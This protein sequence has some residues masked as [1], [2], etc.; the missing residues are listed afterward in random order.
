M[1]AAI[2]SPMKFFRKNSLRF[3]LFVGILVFLIPMNLILLG[4]TVYSKQTIWQ[5]A[6]TNYSDYVTLVSKQIDNKL[7]DI[8]T[9]VANIFYVNDFL[10]RMVR[11]DDKNTRYLDAQE[12]NSVVTDYL[13]LYSNAMLFFIKCDGISIPSVSNYSQNK[14]SIAMSDYIHSLSAES[15]AYPRN[16]YFLLPLDGEWYLSFYFERSGIYL[17]MLIE[18]SSLLNTLD[19]SDA[20]YV[21]TYFSDFEGTP[22]AGEISRKDPYSAADDQRS[23]TNLTVES[24]PATSEYM[25]IH[26]PL[27]NAPAALS[28]QVP[29][30]RI[31]G[32]LAGLQTISI[33]MLI[34]S[35]IILLCF[36]LFVQRQAILPLQRLKQTILKIES[37]QLDSKVSTDGT[38]EEIADVYRTFNTFMDNITTLKLQAYEEKLAKQQTEMQFLRLQLRPHFFLNSLKSIYALAQRSQIGQIQEYVLCLSNHYRFLIYDTTEKIPLRDELLHTQN[39]IQLQRIGYNLSI[40]CHVSF[41]NIADT[42]EVPILILQTFVE[43]SIKYAAIPGKLLQIFIHAEVVHSDEASHIN[44]SIRDN[45]PGFSPD[46]LH[47]M[48]TDEESFYNQHKGFG[49]LK[50]RLALMYTEE[51]FFYIY[52]HPDQGA[53]VEILLPCGEEQETNHEY[54]YRR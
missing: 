30:S 51:T 16:E 32:R 41:N 33:A 31:L 38:V 4:Y 13:R 8:Q 7:S 21:T 48:N 28:A 19:F 47:Q 54:T 46:I 20:H 29:R 42:Q 10:A 43:N 35:V 50:R 52:N 25:T 34:F 15:E 40:E 1:K 44:F 6:Y 2:K 12:I 37:G 26:V 24:Y 23:E 11:I 3:R 9:Y 22:L 45:G 5:Q 18:L 36:I 39:Y 53:A 14:K 49:N 27:Q 17:G